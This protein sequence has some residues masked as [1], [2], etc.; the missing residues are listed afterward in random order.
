MP[1]VTL[2]ELEALGSEESAAAPSKAADLKLEADDLPDF[3]KGKTAADLVDQVNKLQQ[4]LRISEDSRLALRGAVESRPEP[5]AEEPEKPVALTREQLQELAKEDP[6]AAMEYMSQQLVS[7]LDNHLNTRFK[8]LV[9]GNIAASE[10]NAME[11]YKDEFELFKD[12]IDAV[13][14]QVHPQIL[15]TTKGW[16]DLMS[17]VRGQPVNFEKLVERKAGS[18]ARTRESARQEQIADSGF[19]PREVA[20]A[21]K[22]PQDNAGLDETELEICKVMNIDPKDY[23]R[24]R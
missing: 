15:T 9:D 7:N 13:K 22:V 6:L 20:R 24:Y 19:T 12:Q 21:P 10:R 3:A 4:A 23:K 14:K 1:E 11:K 16:D 17:Y 5:R 2:D 8:P 18:Q